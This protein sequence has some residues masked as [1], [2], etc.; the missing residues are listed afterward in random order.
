MNLTIYCCPL[1]QEGFLIKVGSSHISR[2]ANSQQQNNSRSHPRTL[3]GT[4]ELDCNTRL[5]FPP[6][7]QTSN[8]INK[9]L[10]I[11]LTSMLLL[12]STHVVRSRK[13]WWM[14]NIIIAPSATMKAATRREFSWLVSDWFLIGLQPSGMFSNRKDSYQGLLVGHQGQWQ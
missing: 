1:G 3:R 11:S 9:E 6:V 13:S 10:V 7:E 4:S 14:D 12:Y 2:K 5:E 8:P